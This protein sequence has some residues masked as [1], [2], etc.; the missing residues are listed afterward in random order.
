MPEYDR[1]W[2][3]YRACHTP[4]LSGTKGELADDTLMDASITEAAG[5]F[6]K[7]TSCGSPWHHS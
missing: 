4:Y 7:R 3:G 6:T 1:L 5:T 2:Q